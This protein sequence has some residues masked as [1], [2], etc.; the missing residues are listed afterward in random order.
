VDAR[1]IFGTFTKFDELL[2]YGWNF[3]FKLDNLKILHK[4]SGSHDPTQS[5]MAVI[6]A[7]SVYLTL[8]TVGIHN[9]RSNLKT[10]LL[11]NVNLRIESGDR[12]GV[13]GPNGSGKTSLLRMLSGIY[14]P[15]SGS[16]Q[17]SG[18]V[19]CLLDSGLGLEL[20]RT[21]VENI[22]IYG[23][24]RGRK[25]KDIRERIDGILGFSGLE[26][27]A[28]TPVRFYSQ[29]MYLRLAFTLATEWPA[30]ILV[31]DEGI[32]T[33]DKEF[34][35]KAT[36]RMKTYLESTSILLIATHSKEL[37]ESYCSSA[38]LMKD[39]KVTTYKSIQEAF[40]DY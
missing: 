6:N 32:G 29:G 10:K 8:D 24:M 13:I 1:P 36:M 31:I 11:D 25:R 33:G 17:I 21:A 37:I 23:L 5:L 26:S 7:K 27:F 9:S 38:I 35:S 4:E 39:G 28:D 30:E 16:I 18:K 22:W 14:Q 19:S 2:N 3:N 34:Q 12:I 15:T 40:G 20:E